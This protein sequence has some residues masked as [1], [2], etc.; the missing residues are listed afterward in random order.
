MLLGLG[1]L[2]LVSIAGVLAITR[3]LPA[4]DEARA[5]R[6]DIELVATR[7]MTSGLAIDRPTIEGLKNDVAAGRRR[8]DELADLVANDPLIGVARALPPTNPTCVGW[9][10]WWPPR[11]SCSRRLM[12]GLRSPIASS[13][14]RQPTS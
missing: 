9:T 1:L 11:A 4:I 2:A 13:R 3:Y 8:L 6:A 12:R 10:P 7:A 5:L 14:S